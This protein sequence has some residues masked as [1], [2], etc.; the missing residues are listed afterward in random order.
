MG[1]L[2]NWPE[3]GWGKA[4]EDLARQQWEM[5]MC[6]VRTIVERLTDVATGTTGTARTL[7][8]QYGTPPQAQSNSKMAPRAMTALPVIQEGDVVARVIVDVL[9]GYGRYAY[10][11]YIANI[12]EATI[13]AAWMGA[14]GG[15]SGFFTLPASGTVQVPC[16]VRGVIF[17]AADPNQAGQYQVSLQ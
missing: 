12:G 8:Y 17:E 9:E 4:A 13:K 11:G 16:I 7:A 1:F 15:T 6:G 2:K 14:D 5:L 3:G 10:A